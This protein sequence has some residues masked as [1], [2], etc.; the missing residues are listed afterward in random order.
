ME[1]GAETF[2]INPV[3]LPH[4][5]IDIILGMNWMTE[6]N[7]VLDIGS[8]TIQLRSRVSGK[9]IRVHMPDMKHMVATVNATELDEIKKIPVVCDFPDVFPEELPGL[10]PDRDVEFRIDLVPGTAPVSK[11]PYRM[12][13]DE[14]KELKIQLQEQ[15]D[16]GFIR[17]SSSPWGCPAL[18]VEK[19]DQGG[20]RLCVDYRP[21]NAVTV[22]NKYPIPHI[23]ILFDQLAGAKVFSKID[24]RSGYYQ[25]KIREEDIPKTAFSTRYG[26]YEYLVMSFGLTNAPAFF[27]Y[28]MNSVFMNELDK[29]V[30]VFIDDILIYSKNEKEHEEHLRVVLTR[31]REHKLYAKFSKCAFWLKEVGFLGHILSEKGVAVDPSKVKDVLNWKQ[32]ETVTEI[33]SFL[34]L[35]GYYRRFIKDFSK[36][37]KPMTSLTKKNAKFVWGPKC[38]DGFRELKK[39]LTTAPVLAQ[40]DVTKPFDVY[41]DASGQ[42]LGCVLMQE[43]R[44]I[45]YASRQ[46]RKHEANY[47]THDLELAAVVHALKIWRHY[48]LGNTCHIYTD[49]KSLKYIFTQPELNMRQRRWLKLIKDYDLEIH[50]HPGKANVVADALSRRAHCNV[51]EARPTG[52]VICW[53]M[54]EIEMPTEQL[55]ELYSLIIEP[56]IKD[57]VI[58]AQK[59]D[60]GMAH[61]REGIDEEK[62]ACFTLD[63]QGV[64]WFNNRLIVPKDMELRK[65]ILDEAH[66][67]VLT[68]HPG[69]NKMYQDL[70]QKFWWTR[71]KREIAK[72][73]SECDVCKRVK[74]DHLKPGGMLQPL[75]IP[76]WKWEDIHMDFV[77][78][79]PRTQKGYDS[80]WVII[81]R[82][83]KSA[84]FIPV[85]TCYTAA[86]YAG[87]YISRIVSLHGIPVTITSDRGSV[88]VSRFWEHLQTALGTKLIRS[89]AY[90]P[91]TSGQVERVN[92]IVEDMLRA[93]ALTYSTKWDEC[94]PLA[95]FAYNNSYQKRLNMAPFEALYGRRCRT[96]LN[97]SE[98]GERVTFGPDLVTQAE[99]QVKFIQSNLKSAQSRQK[100]YS[101]RRR[102]PL[103]F[104]KGDHVYLRVSP[105]KGV[106]RFGVKGK[107]APRYVGPFKITEQCG[108]V[109]YRL[110]LPPHLAAVHD[111]FHVSQLKKCLRVPEKE[112][113]T[114]QVQIEP[115]LTYEARPIKILDQKQRSTRRNTVNFYK[116]QWSDHSE[117]EATWETEEYL[118]TKHPDPGVEERTREQ[119]PI[120]EPEDP[121]PY[122]QQEDLRQAADSAPDDTDPSEEGIVWNLI[123]LEPLAVLALAPIL[124][125][126]PNKV[127]DVL[128]WKQPQTVTEIRSFLGLADYYRRFIKDFSKIA[129]P[130]TVL[131]QKNAKFAW[132][133]KCEEAFRTLKTL[134]TSAPVLAQPDITKP[135]DV[136][137]DASS[138]GLVCILMQEGR[139]IAYASC[140]LRKHEVNYPTHN[141]E[142]LTVVYA[143]KKWRHYLLGNTCHIYTDHKSLKYIFT[144]PELNMRQRRWLELIKDYDLEVH[145]PGKTTYWVK[146]YAELY[147]SRIVSLHG[148]PQTIT[149]DRG[150]LFVSRFWEQLQIALGTNLIRSSAYHPQTSG[151]VERV[152][153][154]LEDM[155]RACALT[156]STKWDECLPLAE[157]AYNNSYQKSLD[158]APFEALYGRR[159]R[160]PLN[161]SE[162]GER[163]TFSP[164]LVTQAEEQAKFIHS[165]LK[166]AQSRQKSYSGKRRRPLVFEKGDHVY[167]RVSPVKEVHQFGVKGKLAPRYIGPFKITR[168]CGPVAY[169]LELPPHLAAVHDVF[170]VSQLKKCLRVPEEVIDTSQIQIQPDIT[171]EEKPIKVLD[172]KQRSTRRRTIDFYK[173]Q[174]SNHS[175][176]E[177][178]WKQEE[179]LRTKYPGFLPST[180]N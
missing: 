33:R 126:D 104:E 155:L 107:L 5:G 132:S 40:P 66:T 96:P 89:S 86:T 169:R 135:F 165:N 20:K 180:S 139:V 162:P 45:A 54:D 56:T 8:R 37:A 123:A 164:D 105:M 101:D 115:D 177:A 111:V 78:G 172:Q 53:E 42:G 11:R 16:K 41:C 161:W 60:P 109:A 74:A 46:L 12:A 64:L 39:L 52:R 31:L 77:V 170:H 25:I 44:V 68:M 91:Q 146:Q 133:S 121:E 55:V 145:F 26:L 62:K 97:W 57:L 17:P 130:M 120:E 6:N 175:E 88:F 15:L 85:K 95:E 116:V 118:Q 134:L 14:L 72:Y 140:Q 144:Q 117:E 34:G 151:Q 65:K 9:V 167:L 153:Q 30:V 80:I 178:T 149:S 158:M 48:L 47:P 103:V 122:P 160:T 108:P 156:Y 141:L 19:K 112:V 3:V 114:S 84:H 176:E 32:P 75:N 93:C 129:K 76:A 166:R 138:S 51:I 124:A 22:K 27:M 119:P 87:L 24:L 1:I 63:D 18:F 100:S 61:I 21:L 58:V 171:Y 147:I 92:Q 36:I 174:W 142:L 81:D 131:T 38:E 29:F 157:F 106:H 70:K 168:Q 99:E 173:V 83:T 4:Q 49:H 128:N 2:I 179:F 102:R 59:Q 137:C 43:G 7:A 71:M 69:S 154:I 136:Y 35:A 150:S 67:S 10:P 82:F 50:Y 23:D 163:V 73:V 127:E 152:N 79:L 143:L 159:C 28:M 110:E 90:H 113:D 125:V 94:L 98:P 13:P 148:V